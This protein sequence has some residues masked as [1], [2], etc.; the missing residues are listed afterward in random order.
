MQK[1]RRS[2]VGGEKNN[3]KPQKGKRENFLVH[4]DRGKGVII[5]KKKEKVCFRKPKKKGGR[6]FVLK[7]LGGKKKK[8]EGGGTMLPLVRGEGRNVG[9]HANA[10]GRKSILF[11]A[12]GARSPRGKMSIPTCNDGN[13]RT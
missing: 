13:E 12:Q 9:I 2:L 10:E 1:K 6:Q 3:Q 11:P 8:Q 5:T 4:G 7:H